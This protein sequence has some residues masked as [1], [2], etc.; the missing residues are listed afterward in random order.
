MG[1][2]ESCVTGAEESASAWHANLSFVVEAL[3]TEG[4]YE[5]GACDVVCVICDIWATLE[6]EANGIYTRR[7]I[8]V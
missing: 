6:E 7:N 8:E 3:G 4:N 1:L 2:G 5:K